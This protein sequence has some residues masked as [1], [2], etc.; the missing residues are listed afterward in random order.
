MS[1]TI[2]PRLATLKDALVEAQQVLKE[3]RAEVERVREERDQAIVDRRMAGVRADNAERRE[4]A[5]IQERDAARAEARVQHER[6]DNAVFDAGRMFAQLNEARAE[7]EKIKEAARALL[8]TLD[9]HA[10][11]SFGDTEDN[12]RDAIAALTPTPP[13]PADEAP[14]ICPAC[15]VPETGCMHAYGANQPAD[16]VGE[17]TP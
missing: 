17:D 10:T 16:E 6:A 1:D 5:R 4:R 7:V 2:D 13:Q 14:G 11:G 9:E 15:R 3:A 8:E 12:L